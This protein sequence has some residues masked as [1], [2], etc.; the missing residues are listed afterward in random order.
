MIG[1]RFNALKVVERTLNGKHGHTYWICQ[2][3][4]GVRHIVRGNHLRSGQVS[5][6]G[7]R[8][9]AD[10]TKPPPPRVRNAVWIPLSKGQFALVDA[11]DAK[12]VASL[13]WRLHADGYAVRQATINGRKTDIFLHNFLRAPPHGFQ[14][15]HKNRNR[16][17]NRRANLRVA[18]HHQN[19]Q[20]GKWKTGPSGFIGVRRLHGRWQARLHLNGRLQVVGTFET[21]EDAARA[22]DRAAQQ[23]RGRFA[24]LNFTVR[25]ST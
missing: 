9:E 25:K 22:R 20:N 6:C 8:R 2:C 3:T 12:R 11:H 23:A 1:K 24:V 17:D 13:K 18:T 16:L 19:A 5:A 4:C 7:H 15:D 21:R 14:W 10:R